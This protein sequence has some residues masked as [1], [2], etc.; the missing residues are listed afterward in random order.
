MAREEL[1]LDG[2]MIALIMRK[3]TTGV[4]GSKW[5]WSSFVDLL[6]SVGAR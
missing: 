5:A 4:A 3:G 2:L 1:T 6:A